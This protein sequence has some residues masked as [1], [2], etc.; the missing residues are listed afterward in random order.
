MSSTYI[1]ERGPFRKSNR[2]A[3]ANFLRGKYEMYTGAER[4]RSYPSYLTFDPSDVC[5]LR[6]PTCPTG[7]ENHSK[8]DRSSAP[9]IYRRQRTQLGR[10]LFDA[11]MDEMGE[12]LFLIVFYDWGEPLLN[13][14]LPDFIRAAHALEIETEINT[15]LSL[16]LT[17]AFIE[18]LLSSGLDYIEVSIDGFSQATYETHRRGGN[19]ELVKSNLERLAATRERLGLETSITYNFI[20]FSFNE[21]EIRAARRYA[22]QLGVNF[23]TR[24]AFT[25]DREWLPSYR[26]NEKPRHSDEE[27]AA[28]PTREG[29]PRPHY[30]RWTPLQD[31]GGSKSISACGWHYGYSVITAGGPVQPCCAVAHENDD[32]GTVVPGR[33]RFAD[34]WNGDR[35]RGSRAAFAGRETV[36]PAADTVCTSCYFPEMMQHM[37]SLHDM[38][39]I[40]RFNETL[41]ESEPALDAAFR[42]FGRTRFGRVVDALYRRGIFLPLV[43][44]AVLNGDQANVGPF[45]EFYETYLLDEKAHR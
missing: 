12:Y 33:T 43:Q 20:V 4:V 38:K 15:N 23:N 29:Q 10:E 22:R 9:T 5:Q 26:K 17:D 2:S 42:L 45:V 25:D 36:D 6:C 27:L 18:D 31:R 35:Y 34:V 13:K 19:L 21:H 24:D 14:Q 41:A 11:V 39:V 8:R 28:L 7:I 16:R 40:A 1:G 30:A 3:Y 37:Y 32:F 44:A